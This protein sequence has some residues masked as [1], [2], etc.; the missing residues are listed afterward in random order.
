ML[1]HNHMRLSTH[2]AESRITFFLHCRYE[3]LNKYFP[4]ATFGVDLVSFD[5]FGDTLT[6]LGGAAAIPSRF[7]ENGKAKS[8]YF[9]NYIDWLE[10]YK[11]LLNNEP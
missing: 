5:F 10:K 3:I 2:T 8:E 7:D 9:Q 11:F 6:Y 4:H 1:S